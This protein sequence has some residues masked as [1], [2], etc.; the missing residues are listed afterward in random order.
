MNTRFVLVRHGQTAWNRGEER[1][2]GHADLPLDETGVAQAQKVAAHLAGDDI[3]AIYSSPLQRALSTA[4]PT[5][6]S[7]HL[8]I[9]RHDGL[10]DISFGALE[11]MTVQEARI[12][13]PDVIDKWLA[14]PGHVKF[15]KGD[16]FKIVRTRI[17]TMLEELC[18]KHAGATVALF[19]HKIVCGAMLCVVLGLDADALWRV[20]Q[21][22]ACVDR[23]ERRD[24]GWVL[25]VMNDTSHLG[26]AS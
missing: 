1:F 6:D 23:F 14:A 24:N 2:R 25:T 18:V 17:E 4:Q 10:L 13:F 19:S 21:D 9:Q 5:A 3:A 26:S 20:Q 11:G 15:P 7:H 22:N 12:A 16:A 8:E